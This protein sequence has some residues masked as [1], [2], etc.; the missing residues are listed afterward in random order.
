MRGQV[1]ETQLSKF[2]VS[3]MSLTQTIVNERQ[4]LAEPVGIYTSDSQYD[5]KMG[6]DHAI[7]DS[8][9]QEANPKGFL[10]ALMRSIVTRPDELGPA[11]TQGLDNL[12]I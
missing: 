5:C 12:R 7:H 6:R 11:G 3:V 8:S 2:R 4:P 1:L 9:A 10:P